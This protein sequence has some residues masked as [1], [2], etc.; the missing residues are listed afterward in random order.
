MLKSVLLRDR[1]VVA[2]ALA[3]MSL[4]G[5]WWLVWMDQQTMIMTGPAGMDMGMAMGAEA[6][7]RPTAPIA[8]TAVA[9][10]LMWFDMMVAMMLP[11]AAPMILLYERFAEQTRRAG[12]ALL[13]T[14][15]FAGLY[16]TVWAAFSLVAT[17]AQLFLAG[18]G[19]VDGASLAFGDR[20]VAGALL[21]AAALYQLTPAKQACLDNCRSPLG[22][23]R[24]EWGPG[25]A[26]A[27]R[28]GLKHGA[29]CVGCCWLIMALL[30]VGGVMN[31]A[32]VAALALL[33]L[34]EKFLPAPHVARLAIAA[35]GMLGGGYLL[36]A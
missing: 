15:V 30:F 14:M 17:A 31:L 32:W 34:I 3:S 7:R 2:I 20:H 12:G 23:L 27:V 35:A 9:T 19:L 1:W 28:L 25:W 36:L 33:V 10:F 5:W 11:S 16:L 13:P 29:Y 24:R 21:V 8:T 26:S 6:M 18:I 4:L 22:F